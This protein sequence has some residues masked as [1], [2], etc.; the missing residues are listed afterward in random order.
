VSSG[1]YLILL[2]FL[3]VAFIIYG[4]AKLKLH[5]FLV[6]LVTAIGL[7]LAAGLPLAD[8]ISA[9]TD[10]FGSTV[11]YI[12]IIIAAGSIIG[13]MLEKSGGAVVMAESI[14]RWIGKAQTIF[15]MSLTGSIISIPVYCDS[16]FIILSPLN[17]SL[18]KKANRS[19]GTYAVALSMGLYATHVFVPPTPGPIAAAAELDASIGLVMLLG[20]AVTVPVLFT[21][22]FYAKYIG[23]KIHI[24]PDRETVT[25]PESQQNIEKQNSF[26]QKPTVFKAFLPIAVP[27]IL[28]ALNSIT[29]LFGES[30]GGST[31]VQVIQFL[32]DPNI[33]LLLGVFFAF[34]TIEQKGGN[35][36]PRLGGNSPET[37]RCHYI[38]NRC[39]RGTWNYYA[40][41]GHWQLSRLKPVSVKFG[42]YEHLFAVH[43]GCCPKDNPR[44]LNCGYYNI[45]FTHK[46]AIG[47]SGISHRTRH[48]VGD[49]GHRGRGD[50]CFTRQRQL[51]LGGMPILQHE[52]LRSLQ[53]AN[54]FIRHRRDDGNYHGICVEPFSS[55]EVVE[56]PFPR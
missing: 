29:E 55:V 35:G 48:R 32:G 54:H 51:F 49:S 27:L 20:I 50:D 34:L 28:I 47:R 22:Y 42:H 15:A 45:R 16:G 8:V 44:L 21:T 33:A 7:G 19:V 17:K 37:G 6:L 14:I 25:E 18:A 40:T 39:R 38:N 26:H 10:G 36:L 5:A 41:N 9:V 4:T 52:S 13:T 46:S 2:L 56:I 24:D 23:D 53:T 43:F 30:G 1:L 31:T 12:G 11:G 3:A